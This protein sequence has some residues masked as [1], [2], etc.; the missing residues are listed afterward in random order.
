[1]SFE[2]GAGDER[3]TNFKDGEFLPVQKFCTW[4]ERMTTFVWNEELK[5]YICENVS[6]HG[7][8]HLVEDVRFKKDRL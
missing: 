2:N 3:K 7:V 6:E 4:H 5:S 8:R 1:M